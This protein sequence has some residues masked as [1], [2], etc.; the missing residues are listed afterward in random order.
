[1]EC[2]KCNKFITLNKIKIHNCLRKCERCCKVFSSFQ[3]L[4][5]HINKK[6]CLSKTCTYCDKKFSSVQRLKSHNLICI[7]HFCGNK[8]WHLKRCSENY[9]LEDIICYDHGDLIE[10]CCKLKY[11]KECILRK[12]E[13]DREH[14]NF[15]MYVPWENRTY[16]TSKCMHCGF[17]RQE[18][19]IKICL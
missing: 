5:H 11:I 14:Y 16:W 12:K 9:N 17:I 3:M 19:H 2:D 13:I 6:I 18:E 8:A 10:R 4:Q 1:M 15:D 7:K